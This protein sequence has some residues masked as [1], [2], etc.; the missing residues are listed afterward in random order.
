MMDLLA[1]P[2][3]ALRRRAAATSCVCCNQPLADA[4]SVSLG[5][6]PTCRKRLGVDAKLRASAQ[7]NTLVAKAAIAA[8]EARL[9][10]VVDCLKDLLALD[11]AYKPLV[12]RVRKRLFKFRLEPDGVGGF[13]LKFPYNRDV[14]SA[15]KEFG[16]WWRPVE[17]AW[18]AATLNQRDEAIA[19]LS[20]AYPGGEILMEGSGIVLAMNSWEAA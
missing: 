17:K 1:D 15:L 9:Q 8:E 2:H 7:A 3:T 20:E 10:A 11:A 19:V 13:L 4:T 16:L 5:M 12:D 14:I 18:H 6:G